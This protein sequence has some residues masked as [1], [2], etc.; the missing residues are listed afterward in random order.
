MFFVSWTE[1][2]K[3]SSKVGYFQHILKIKGNIQRKVKLMILIMK[4]ETGVILKLYKTW[5][6]KTWES[7]NQDWVCWGN[8]A[9]G[10]MIL[11][12]VCWFNSNLLNIP[13]VP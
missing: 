2:A 4:E 8:T 9:D 13:N 11:E 6:R 3:C 10:G 1:H 12:D 7:S 5:F